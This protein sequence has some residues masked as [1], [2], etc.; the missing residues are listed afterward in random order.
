[1]KAIISDMGGVV[2]RTFDRRPRIEL[3]R[4][5]GLSYEE[6]DRLVFGA[7]TAQ[8]ATV[9][10]IPEEEHWAAVMAQLGLGMGDLQAFE[11]AFWSGDG[12]D[13]ALLDVI[14]SVRPA[15]CT[16][17]LSNAWSLARREIGNRF[18]AVLAPFDVT[19]FSAEVR[20]AKPDER[21]YRLILDQLGVTA[22]EAV[23]IDDY[24]PNVEAAAALGLHTIHFREPEQARAGLL[25][26]IS[27]DG[28]A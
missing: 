13:Q 10:E 1:M 17:L 21:I 12:V 27:R 20:L 3:A 22:G 16:G 11:D 2:L 7:E 23:F 25:E 8:R 15:L 9:G 18:P 5:F 26:L 4:R 24:L 6:M 19:I 14:A 28:H